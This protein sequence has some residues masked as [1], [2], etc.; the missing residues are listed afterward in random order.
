MSAPEQ[1]QQ[2]IQ[3]HQQGQIARAAAMYRRV[4]AAAPDHVDALHFLGIAEHQQGRSEE[5]L[6][7]MGRSI[8]L[9]PG[10]PDTHVNRANVLRQLGRASEAEASY[11]TALA[12]RPDDPKALNNLAALLREGDRLGE[13]VALLRR[14]ATLAPDDADA[15][16]NLGQALFALGQLDEGLQAFQRAIR[17]RPDAT[18]FRRMGAAFYGRGQIAEAAGAYR[19][20]LAIEPGS[21]EATHLLAGCTAEGAPARASDAFV[22]SLFDRF[23]PSF[24]HAL[25]RLDYRAPALVAGA[26]AAAVGAPAGALAI[27]D[28]GCGT[29]LC[30]GPLR[31][32]AKSLVGVDLSPNMLE[33]ARRRSVYDS[34]VEAE[35]CDFMSRTP[36]SYDVIVSADTLVYFGALEEVTAAAARALRPRGL[37]AF[38]TERSTDAEAPEGRRLHPHG[39][40]S[41]T[42]AY[43]RRVLGDAGLEV[44]A[45]R[46]VELRKEAGARVQGLLVAAR[47]PA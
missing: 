18:S 15:Q 23:A 31:P 43:L 2:A 16:Q 44:M 19:Q 7:L 12:L 24:D 38:T 47:R 46:E 27:L 34:L 30:A 6:R 35:L 36:D 20:W 3:I 39:R 17:I 32:F 33:R 21:P 40:Y 10:H 14:L 28:A 42:E 45:V 8:E 5:A 11:R 22:R 13:S 37:L 29:G 25:E 26:V 9:E 41:H 4:L 1:V